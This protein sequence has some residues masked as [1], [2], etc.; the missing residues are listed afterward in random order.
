[1][2]L[3]EKI[4]PS[5]LETLLTAFRANSMTKCTADLPATDHKG[6]RSEGAGCVRALV[7]MCV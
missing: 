2:L 1:M 3:D 7:Y 6:L 5:R 4:Y